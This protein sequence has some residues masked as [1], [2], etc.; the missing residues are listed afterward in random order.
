[1]HT[2][3]GH[4]QEDYQVGLEYDLPMLMP[5]DDL[6]RFTSEAPEFEGL[7]V[8]D[9]NIAIIEDLKARGLLLAFRRSDSLLPTLLEV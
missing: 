6:G 4:G 8:D 1:M 3:P 9:A 5:V 7:F 2:A